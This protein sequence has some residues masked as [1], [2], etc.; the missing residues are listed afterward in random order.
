MY[1]GLL[2]LSKRSNLCERDEV[3]FGVFGNTPSSQPQV[4]LNTVQVRIPN[5]SGD[6][7]SEGSSSAS[8]LDQGFCYF[9]RDQESSHAYQHLKIRISLPQFPCYRPDVCKRM[10]EFN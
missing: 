6:T 7:R 9:C 1:R 10:Q 2:T 3:S 4:E 8:R 5:L